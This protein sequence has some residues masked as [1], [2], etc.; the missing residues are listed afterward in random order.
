MIIA[1]NNF[2]DEEYQQPKN[3]LAKNRIKVTTASS[4]IGVAKGKLGLETEVN[5]T[6]DQVIVA[7]FDA[8]LFVGGGGC[9]EYFDNEI[10]HKIAR[11]A[12]KEKKVLGALCA[13]PEI[14]AR[15]GVLKGKRA[16]MFYDN[17]SLRRGGAEFTDKDVEVDG[18]IIT[19]R[20][21]DTAQA[22][23]EAIVKALSD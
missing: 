6:I 2:R 17:G 11:D 8:I 13:A 4:S 19:A 14:L 7:D 16:T 21:A 18:R 22:W 15:A 3:I 23:G 1:F 9:E 10:A 5:L 12:V 20:N